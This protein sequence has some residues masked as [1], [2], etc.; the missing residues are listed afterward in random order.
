MAAF[1]SWTVLPIAFALAAFALVALRAR[2]LLFDAALDGRPFAEALG[3]RLAAADL[4]GARA[5]AERMRPAWAAEVAFRAAGADASERAFVLEE[6]RAEFAHAAQRGLLPIQA[7]G[8]LALPLA[9]AVA[10]VELAHGFDPAP[11]LDPV[12][13]GRAALAQGMF[14]CV[15]GLC[16]ALACQWS[17]NLLV[18]AAQQRLGEVE[19]ISR[20]FSR[21]T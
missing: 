16:T 13:A 9:L 8:R 11:A 3:A 6:A 20:S 17:A 14:A 19:R 2:A 18:R 7:L 21:S 15:I 1:A 10:I 4:T 12:T 5:L